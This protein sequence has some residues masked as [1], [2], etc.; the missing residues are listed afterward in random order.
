[1]EK[2]LSYKAV[3]EILD[4]SAS[5][6]QKM[7]LAGELPIIKVGNETRVRESVLLRWLEEREHFHEK[8]NCSDPNGKELLPTTESTFARS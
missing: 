2:L 5:K 1:M 4:C 7:C 3:A 8:K 6:V